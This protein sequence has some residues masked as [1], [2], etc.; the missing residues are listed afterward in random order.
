[1]Q[2][3]I[4]NLHLYKTDLIFYLFRNRTMDST[5]S[6]TDILYYIAKVF[7]LHNGGVNFFD[8]FTPLT[9]L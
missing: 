6:G 8:D 2:V 4:N 7:S 5:C 3:I 9:P 1:M